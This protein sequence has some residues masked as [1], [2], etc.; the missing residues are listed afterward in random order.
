M[1]NLKVLLLPSIPYGLYC[2]VG[3]RDDA[4]DLHAASRAL[5]GLGVE[6][7]TID[8][9]GFPLNPLAGRHPLLQSLDPFRTLHAL[10]IGRRY[11]LVISGNDGPA[12]LLVLLRRLFRLKV[13]ILVWDLSPAVKWRLRM[14][15]QDV[16]LPKVD[17][18]LALPSMQE[19]YV[20]ERW[21]NRVC[22]VTIGQFIDTDFFRPQADSPG[23][24]ILSVGDDPGRDYQ[25][26]LDAI[27][28]FDTELR[29]KTSQILAPGPANRAR[30]QFISTR[31]SATAL[32]TLYAGCGFV[33]VPLMPHPRNACGVSTILEAGAMGKA[34][35]VSES[36]GIM[37]F[38]KPGET[39]LMV[40]AGDTRALTAAIERLRCE[41]ETCR[42]LGENA[43]RFV[44]E[45]FA[46]VPFARRLAGALGHFASD[47]RRQ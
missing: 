37:D 9:Y 2:P 29:I 33:V 30:I 24:Y 10:W 34:M 21:G 18:I 11:D 7:H 35:I 20:R 26:L 1:R 45:Q 19:A 28:N 38:I 22:T 14:W 4:P 40:P 17:G 44:Q 23:N 13:P 5:A 32:R 6:V 46:P 8:P 27:E 47:K 36:D 16:T 39:C 41:P 25:T 42:R 31:L 12:V 43:R 3:K 15:L